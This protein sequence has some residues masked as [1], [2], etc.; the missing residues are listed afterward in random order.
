MAALRFGRCW[1]SAMTIEDLDQRLNGLAPTVDADAALA[2]LGRP[3]RRGRV[4]AGAVLASALIL[5]VAVAVTRRDSRDSTTV[6]VAVGPSTT[7]GDDSFTASTT[8]DG[9]ELTVT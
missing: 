6:A 5:G 7:T 3:R 8:S 2:S 4:I 9:I 1:R